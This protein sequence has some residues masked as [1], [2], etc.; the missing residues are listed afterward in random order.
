MYQEIEKDSIDNS[1]W[2]Q[3]DIE[4]ELQEIENETQVLIGGVAETVFLE[5]DKPGL[6]QVSLQGIEKEE[7]KTQQPERKGK[8][9]RYDEMNDKYVSYFKKFRKQKFWKLF[10]WYILSYSMSMA[11]LGITLR[12]ILTK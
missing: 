2:K 10:I 1:Q 4:R 11:C 6:C 8:A 3:Q 9:G 7:R 12:F 5:E